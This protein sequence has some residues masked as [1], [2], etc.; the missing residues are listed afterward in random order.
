LLEAR[1][2]TAVNSGRKV[3]VFA[4]SN[5]EAVG[6]NPTRGMYICVHLFCV[7]AVLCVDSGTASGSSPVQ[8]V[9]STVYKKIKKGKAIPVTGRGGL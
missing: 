1:L 5:A 7:C 4:S 3:A 2:Q 8:G 6:S 9:L